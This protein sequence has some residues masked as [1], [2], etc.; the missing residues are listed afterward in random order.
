MSERSNR[1]YDEEG[2]ADALTKEEEAK[3]GYASVSRSL[4]PCN[5]S[6]LPYN[7]S[8]L[9]YNRSHLNTLAYVRYASVSG[10]VLRTIRS[11]LPYQQ[12][13]FAI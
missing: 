5:R 10:Y 7:R 11:L 8:L 3:W 6:L 13:S 12:V 1:D 4:L 2:D 9:P